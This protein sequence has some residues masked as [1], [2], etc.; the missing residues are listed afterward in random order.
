MKTL[1]FEVE[2]NLL[3]EI[4]KIFPNST[5]PAEHLAYLALKEWVEWLKGAERPTK[6]SEQN[7]Q[8]F[9]SIYSEILPGE[10]PDA[11]T[12]YNEFNI[13]LG[14]SRYIIQSISYKRTGVLNQLALQDILD[15]INKEIGSSDPIS[16]IRI[17]RISEKIL[18]EIIN[19]LSL[20]DENIPAPSVSKDL[21]KYLE[22][23]LRTHDLSAIKNV[24][25][26]KISG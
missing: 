3:T 8:R 23:K 17:K 22:F 5:T 18:R 9:M 25:Q 24:V 6:I 12:L 16:V 11:E 21:G 4:R 15:S 2:D 19:E 14:Q 10:V 1:R 20:N 7:I 26:S 13:P